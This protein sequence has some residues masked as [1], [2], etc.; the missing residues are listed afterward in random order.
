MI[1]KILLKT[2]GVLPAMIVILVSLVVRRSLAE[3][4]VTESINATVKTSI[5]GDAII[6]GPEDCEGLD[7]NGETCVSIGYASGDLSCEV[8]C[9]FDTTGC[10]PAPS[11]PARIP[12]SGSDDDDDDSDGGGDTTTQKVV[13]LIQQLIEQLTG[14]S[15]FFSAFDINQDGTLDPGEVY[16]AMLRWVISW[17]QEG[18][19][20]TIET[21]MCD[22]NYDGKCNLVDMSVLLYHVG[23]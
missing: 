19:A 6:E 9:E 21:K 23:R 11:A 7:L 5:C 12:G 4:P 10:I 13:Q 3:G 22:L 20:D 14:A 8:N 1:N 18:G 15:P 2:K 17:R 16:K